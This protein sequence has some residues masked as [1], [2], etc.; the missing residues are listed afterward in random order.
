MTNLTIQNHETAPQDTFVAPFAALHYYVEESPDG[1]KSVAL[2][3]DETSG[4]SDITALKE[5]FAKQARNF[6]IANQHVSAREGAEVDANSNSIS[7]MSAMI[8]GAVV[9]AMQNVESEVLKATFDEA[10]SQKVAF[11]CADNAVRELTI[12]ELS[13]ALQKALAQ[14]SSKIIGESPVERA[15]EVDERE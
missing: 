9:G 15:G 13:T 3:T 8:V 10:F 5:H 2:S 14:T 11:K 1:Y 12:A 6:A 7:T 4:F